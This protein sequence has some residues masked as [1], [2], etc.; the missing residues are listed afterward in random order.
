MEHNNK[1]IGNNLILKARQT[2]LVHYLRARHPKSI[3][4]AAHPDEPDKFCWRGTA[5]DSIT[6]FT[7]DYSGLDI[8]KYYR[9]S[10]RESDDGIAYLVRYEGYRFPDAVRALAY[11]S[12][13][14]ADEDEE[15]PEPEQNSLQKESEEPIRTAPDTTVKAPASLYRMYHTLC[16]ELYPPDDSLY[17]PDGVDED[18][19]D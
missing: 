14:F 1:K 17:I 18:E 11:F 13:P 15:A 2:D 9:W 19:E 12:D 5:H 16:P 3:A 4:Y 8:S 10:N 6:F 7:A